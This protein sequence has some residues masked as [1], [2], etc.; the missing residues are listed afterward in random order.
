MSNN[1]ANSTNPEPFRLPSFGQALVYGAALGL[2]IAV[3]FRPDASNNEMTQIATLRN[4][5][6]S[7][8]AIGVGLRGIAGLLLPGTS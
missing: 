7:G 6:L 3:V 8:G 2:L 4:Y 5:L 1:D